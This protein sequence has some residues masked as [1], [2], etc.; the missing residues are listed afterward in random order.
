MVL[1][2]VWVFSR[3]ANFRDFCEHTLYS[4]NKCYIDRTYVYT[5]VCMPLCKIA[6]FPSKLTF[7]K[8]QNFALLRITHT[9]ICAYVS[10][11][12]RGGRGQGPMGGNGH[13]KKS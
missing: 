13:G 7:I 4:Q 11:V 5:Y 10:G 6:F 2:M 1:Y 9:A 12:C 3:G 8:T